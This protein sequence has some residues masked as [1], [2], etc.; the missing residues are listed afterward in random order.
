MGVLAPWCLLGLA[1]LAVP[2]YL[3]LLRRH[4]ANPR[5]FSSLLFF[6]PRTQTSVRHRRLHYKLLLALRLLLL[7]LL[8]LA[9][10]DPFINRTLIG[11][12]AGKLVL[13]I[14]D[15]SFS[16][17]A[18][19]RLEDAKREAMA[20]LQRRRPTDRLQVIS[21]G[22]RLAV[23]TDPTQDSATQRAAL[24]GIQADDSRADLS[25]VVS[26]ARQASQDTHAAIE[27]H[28]F[29]DLQRSSLP[30]NFNDLV[31]P[32]AA[33]VVLHP[34]ARSVVPN[35]SI[36]SVTA[37]SQI[38]GSGKELKS[39]PVQ[40]VV[41]GF[42]TPAA[43]RQ[44][45]L[46]VNGRTVASQMVHVPAAGRVTVQF[47]NLAV[48][49]GFSRCEV[50][51]DGGDLLPQDDGFRF[52]VERS[53]PRLVLFVH[54]DSDSRSPLYF[55]NALAAADGAAFNLQSVGLT[56]A[57]RLALDPYAFVVISNLAALPPALLTELQRYVTAGGSVLMA[58][59]TGAAGHERVPLFDS[60]VQ[61]T[62]DYASA[63][64]SGA[65]RYAAVGE[66][67]ASQGWAGDLPFWSEVKFFYALQ[68]DAGNAEVVARLTDRTPLL[69]EKR[70]GEGRVLLLA[71]GLDGLTNDLPL[72]P[73]FVA[74]ISQLSRHLSGVQPGTGARLVD[75]ILELHSAAQ[76]GTSAD[77]R[78]E[79]IDPRGQR[80]LSLTESLTTPTLALREAGF[81]Q[82]RR[83]DGRAELIG[84]N[85]DPRESDL[86]L[87][88]PETLALWSPPR[89]ARSPAVVE[90]ATQRQLPYHLEWFIMLL[91]LLAA[92]AQ[93]W[94]ADRH[95]KDD[96]AR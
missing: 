19:S 6:E 7:L 75:S 28:L 57:A 52:A 26:A 92:L 45:S 13:L 67:D 2:L 84:V 25:E 47:P 63:A 54:A 83:A 3:H 37:P 69:L 76:P 78:V 65:E 68:L 17:H 89:A 60:A 96:E 95:L 61:A 49:H 20:E 44:V 88:P 53:D 35:W 79:V 70:L 11:A 90:A 9:F 38:W 42:G 32:D 12:P 46:L 23:L 31:L 91:A 33:S 58:L 80:P 55:G 74:F 14:V 43:D 82:L 87:I 94:V 21:L 40:A 29:S 41:A 51:I 30:S 48:P 73:A 56:A 36:E 5:P 15:R 71:S 64:G 24:A 8:V 39:A 81:Y 59:G 16:M 77:S 1:T 72:R 34:V 22:S 62:H 10:A 86:A 4:A 66:V 18:G 93:A 50:R 27:L 85:P